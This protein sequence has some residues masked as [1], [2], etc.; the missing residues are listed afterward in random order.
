M[1]I[2]ARVAIM[3][4]A[5]T[6]GQVPSAPGLRSLLRHTMGIKLSLLVVVGVH[7]FMG[8][9]WVLYL[10]Q[11]TVLGNRACPAVWRRFFN[12]LF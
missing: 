8:L 10:L 9:L 2:Q 5:A 1:M 12:I 11:R 6:Y 3:K 4:M 7:G